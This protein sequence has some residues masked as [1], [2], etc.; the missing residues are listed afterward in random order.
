MITTM[1]EGRVDE[2]HI[3]AVLDTPE[4]VLTFRAAGVEPVLS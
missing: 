3:S 4:E 1:L 2:E